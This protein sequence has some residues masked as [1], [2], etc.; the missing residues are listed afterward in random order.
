MSTSKFSGNSRRILATV[1][2][3]G[4]LGILGGV[5]TYSAFTA[6]T[7]AGPQTVSSATLNLTSSGSTF[8]DA[9]TAIVPGD[10]IDRQVTLTNTGSSAFGSLDLVTAATTSSLL[11]TNATNGL[12]MQ[13]DKCSVAWSGAVGSELTC[14]GTTTSVVTPGRVAPRTASVAG[15][16]ALNPGGVDH[17]RVRLTLPTTADNSFQGLSSVISYTFSGNQRTASFR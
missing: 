13:V 11:D 17:L 14:S 8:T 9:A 12:Q 5:G 6:T 4:A 1:G 2:V 16:A 7:S 10:R 3:V 15:L